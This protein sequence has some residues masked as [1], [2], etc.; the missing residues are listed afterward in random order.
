MFIFPHLPRFVCLDSVSAGV[1]AA[2]RQSQLTSAA[3][4]RNWKP[5]PKR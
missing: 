2:V 4:D 1:Q 3:S 5:Q